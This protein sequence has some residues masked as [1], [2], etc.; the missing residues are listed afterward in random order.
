M[1]PKSIFDGEATIDK[2]KEKKT[3]IFNN[4][5]KFSSEIRPRDKIVKKNKELTLNT[6]YALYHGW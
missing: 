5:V 4:I 1:F 6:A 2:V 3:N